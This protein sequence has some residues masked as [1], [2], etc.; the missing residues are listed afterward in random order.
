MWWHTVSSVIVY[1]YKVKRAIKLGWSW[2]KIPV[3][4]FSNARIPK[5]SLNW[6]HRPYWRTQVLSEDA[7]PI[8]IRVHKSIQG[9]LVLMYSWIHVVWIRWTEEYNI[10]FC[11][12]SPSVYSVIIPSQFGEY[13]CIYHRSQLDSLNFTVKHR[14]ISS[15]T[16]MI[17]LWI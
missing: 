5:L 8:Y 16:L 6:G 10:Q 17:L 14:N 11:T 4:K 2:E 7:G 9:T 3:L 13:V 1:F 12:P 15:Q